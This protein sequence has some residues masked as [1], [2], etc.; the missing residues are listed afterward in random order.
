MERKKILRF[1]KIDSEEKLASFVIDNVSLFKND[2]CIFLDVFKTIEHAQHEQ[3]IESIITEEDPAEVDVTPVVIE[4]I[5]ENIQKNFGVRESFL[6]RLDILKTIIFCEYILP[7]AKYTYDETTKPLI[8]INLVAYNLLLVLLGESEH[9][10]V[11]YQKVIAEN[12]TLAAGSPLD[13][14]LSAGDTIEINGMIESIL[15]DYLV[16]FMGTFETYL[17]ADA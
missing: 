12:G 16:S 2:Q 13:K 17:G 8:D 1:I 4:K 14:D 5:A 7:G 10:V 9:A 11:A 6:S 3:Y 15:D